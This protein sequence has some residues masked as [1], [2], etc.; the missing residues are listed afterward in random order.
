MMSAVKGVASPWFTGA[1]SDL[2]VVN[3]SLKYL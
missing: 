1:G 2:L 3:V